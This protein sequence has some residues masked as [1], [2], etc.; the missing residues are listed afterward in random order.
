MPD[1]T[2][3]RMMGLARTL[4]LT[5][6]TARSVAAGGQMAVIARTQAMDETGAYGRMMAIV[7]RVGLL[8]DEHA[9]MGEPASDEDVLEATVMAAESF[10][11]NPA[12]AAD[13]VGAVIE[14][15]Q[16]AVQKQMENYDGTDEHSGRDAGLGKPTGEPSVPARSPSG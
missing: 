5:E 7:Q 11:V 8:L 2:T 9:M 4:G 1:S 15:Y 12:L 16:G 3:E 14:V 13:L 10:D 6:G